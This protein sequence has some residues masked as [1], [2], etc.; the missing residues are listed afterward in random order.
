MNANARELFFN[1]SDI[2]VHSRP[3]AAETEG[4]KT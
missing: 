2:R 4:D 3:F 1:Q